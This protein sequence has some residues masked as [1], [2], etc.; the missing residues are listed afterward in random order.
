M[1]DELI[2]DRKHLG[3]DMLFDGQELMCPLGFLGLHID[4]P[5]DVLRGRYLPSLCLYTIVPLWPKKLFE[6]S[7]WIYLTG[8]KKINTTWEDVISE[9][10]DVP[11]LEE[12]LR[13]SWIVMAFKYLLNINVKFIG[14]YQ[15][16]NKNQG[17]V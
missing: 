13:E 10:A 4:I 5:L 14:E 17:T 16:E 6:I 8:N 12:E 11:S 2:I 9:I 1:N 7:S 15:I 3:S